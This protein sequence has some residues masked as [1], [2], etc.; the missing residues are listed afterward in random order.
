MERHHGG[1]AKVKLAMIPHNFTKR[2]V[3]ESRECKR[4]L[5]VSIATNGE[6][7]I[8]VPGTDLPILPDGFSF[9]EPLKKFNVRSFPSL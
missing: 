6:K 7:L 4:K 8:A 5:G 3:N 9:P 2:P 1:G